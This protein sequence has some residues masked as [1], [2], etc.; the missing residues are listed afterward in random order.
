MELE[1]ELELE[2]KLKLEL[3]LE[4]TL[5]LVL[6]MDFFGA[7]LKKSVFKKIVAQPFHM[8]KAFLRADNAKQ[9][10]RLRP[11]MAV[12]PCTAELLLATK[13]VDAQMFCNR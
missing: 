7:V 6:D 12:G 4:L 8:M 13:S 5:K 2:M 11:N 9:S 1:L 10:T 3:E